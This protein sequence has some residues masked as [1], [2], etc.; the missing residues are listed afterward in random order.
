ME[1]K[2]NLMGISPNTFC[3][4]ERKKYIKVFYNN[5][6]DNVSVTLCCL[7]LLLHG[8][9]YISFNA[10]TFLSLL[11]GSPVSHETKTETLSCPQ[12]SDL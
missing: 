3:L 8:Y 4:Y 2:E 9:T 5:N 7:L 6:F 11:G 1:I 10:C 12:P